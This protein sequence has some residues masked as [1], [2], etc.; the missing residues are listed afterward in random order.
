MRYLF[1]HTRSSVR[2]TWKPIVILILSSATKRL[3]N[4]VITFYEFLW[5]CSRVSNRI[6]TLTD[7]VPETGVR[8]RYKHWK[9]KRIRPETTRRK[10]KWTAAR[11]VNRYKVPAAVC[12]R[13]ESPTNTWSPLITPNSSPAHWPL[14]S[15]IV[16][17]C[18]ICE[19][20]FGREPVWKWPERPRHTHA[21][22]SG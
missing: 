3:I 4:Y 13:S 21:K 17:G 1:S 11:H 2:G 12:R 22:G 8:D 9:R 7:L 19:N 10:T 20:T 14:V 6:Y 18:G 15:P 5:H 16:V